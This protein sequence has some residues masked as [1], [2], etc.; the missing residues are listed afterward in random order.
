MSAPRLTEAE[1]DLLLEVL[2]STEDDLHALSDEYA[3][4]PED[5]LHHA[6]VLADVEAV[7]NIRTTL[8]RWMEER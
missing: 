4:N 6:R 3:D 2:S 8:M 5:A 1:W 7:I